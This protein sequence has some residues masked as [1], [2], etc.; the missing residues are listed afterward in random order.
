MR[1][2]LLALVVVAGS[3]LR[4]GFAP[5]HGSDRGQDG[6]QPPADTLSERTSDLAR[7]D[8]YRQETALEDRPRQDLPRQDLPRSDLPRPL[9][10]PLAGTG[11]A[12]HSNG[13]AL[14]AQLTGPHGLVLDGATLYVSEWDGQRVR[15][16]EAGVVSDAAGSGAAGMADGP[17]LT[18]RLNHPAGLLVAQGGLIIADHSNH[19]LRLLA[20]GQLSTLS[21]EGMGHVDGPAAAA[22]YYSPH[23][24]ILD[25]S[26]SGA[27]FISE[28]DGAFVRQLSGGQVS[29]YAGSTPGFAQ[30][31]FAT[32]KFANP[33]YMCWDLSKAT[34]YVSDGWNHQVRALAGG[35]VTTYVG[36]G[37]VGTADGP[38]ATAQVSYPSGLAMDAAGRLFI[39]DSGSGQLRKVENGVVSTVVSG[40]AQPQGIVV[41]GEGTL[42]VAEE[43]GHRV[44]VVYY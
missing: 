42:Y 2:C 31:A 44:T 29:T 22:L 17:A 36:T 39:A 13:P 5:P 16:I 33:G 8:L 19:R 20:G 30:G 38:L 41:A 6:P 25:G 28:W 27:V 14:Q 18:A 43:A 3:C 11:V 40:L 21:G 4:G 23:G 24:L 9:V 34:L 37:V 32:A 26:G 10:Q 1:L 7:Q 12:G 15:R 35:Q